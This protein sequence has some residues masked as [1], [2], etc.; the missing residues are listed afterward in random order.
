MFIQI[1]LCIAF[2][3]NFHFSRFSISKISLLLTWW[4]LHKSWS[5]FIDFWLRGFV[6]KSS[7]QNINFPIFSPWFI[8]WFDQISK[9]H[10]KFSNSSW[11][12][13]LFTTILLNSWLFDKIGEFGIS[14]DTNWCVINDC[15]DSFHQRRRWNGDG[16]RRK[17]LRRWYRL[18][19]APLVAA[20][21]IANAFE[22]VPTCK[23]GSMLPLPSMQWKGEV[24]K[25]GAIKLV[26]PFSFLM[27]PCSPTGSTQLAQ[28]DP[29]W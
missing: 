4:F 1:F 23:V 7:F 3:F 26:P 10:L 29:N 15:I 8:V 22:L 2:D 9:D 24:W 18:P 20:R 5:K 19:P 21:T 27:S 28:V 12:W 6:F 25:G 11:D 17:H 14:F 16:N 13:P